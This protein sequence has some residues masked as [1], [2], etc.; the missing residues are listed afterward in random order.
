M[1]VSG[2]FMRLRAPVPEETEELLVGKPRLMRGA[3]LAQPKLLPGHRLPLVVGFWGETP[4]LVVQAGFKAMENWAKQL[5]QHTAI[6]FPFLLRA[7]TDERVDVMIGTRALELSFDPDVEFSNDCK[8]V[9]GFASMGGT[10]ELGFCE[11][12]WDDQYRVYVDHLASR[13]VCPDDSTRSE[14]VSILAHELGH[15]L[16]LGHE[17]HLLARLMYKHHGDVRK[18]KKIECEWVEEIWT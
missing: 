7:H 5:A 4:E 1:P 15:A 8:V 2:E 6:T 18:P 3:Q 10:D 14:T 16:L 11:H 12:Y 17:E 9:S 13:I